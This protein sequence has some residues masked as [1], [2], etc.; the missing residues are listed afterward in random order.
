MPKT[1]HLKEQCGLVFGLFCNQVNL[2]FASIPPGTLL[3]VPCDLR[4]VLTRVSLLS[5]S[6]YHS[7]GDLLS[8]THLV[9]S[10]VV[11]EYF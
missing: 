8:F 11:H 9:Q 6:D 4:K 2:R 10:S 7:L 1:P 5:L 3:E